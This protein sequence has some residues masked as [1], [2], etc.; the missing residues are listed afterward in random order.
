MWTAASFISFKTQWR[1]WEVIGRCTM[2]TWRLNGVYP[3]NVNLAVDPKTWGSIPWSPGPIWQKRESTTWIWDSRKIVSWRNTMITGPGSWTLQNKLTS[4]IFR[5]IQPRTLKEL[6]WWLM[7]PSLFRCSSI[8]PWT[9]IDILVWAEVYQKA[10][11]ST[12]II[13]YKFKPE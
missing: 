3:I 2:R 6:P 5:V 7:I 4:S 11:G 8:W 9:L 13:F 1:A 12:A 10:S